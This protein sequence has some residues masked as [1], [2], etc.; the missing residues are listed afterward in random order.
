MIKLNAL[1]APAELTAEVIYDLTEIFKN[2]GD[3][4]WT[5]KYIKVSLLEMSNNKCCYCECKVDE[6]S[7][8]LEID[9]FKPK[10][11]FPELVVIWDNLLPACKHCNGHKNDHNT[12]AEPI[13]NPTI[14]NP[15]DYLY[16]SQGYRLHARQL[17]QLGKCSIEVLDLNN[18]ER[19]V[20]KRFEIGEEIQN[21][22]YNLEDDVDTFPNLPLGLQKT[23]MRNKVIRTIRNLLLEAQPASEYSAC[24]A[25]VIISDLYYHKAKN[26]L[27]NHNL[28]TE[29]M[30]ALED[31]AVQSALN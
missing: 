30:Q 6:E 19:L 28:W 22:L 18:R 1:E 2:T 29:E 20:N 12:E 5:K 27:I 11:Q 7:K 17:N 13:I 4:V 8:Y 3:S 9:H 31:I 26:V 25:T 21:K 24:A 14:A 23:K 16:F 15:K 10:E